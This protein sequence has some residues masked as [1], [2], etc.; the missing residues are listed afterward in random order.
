MKNYKTLEG[1]RTPHKGKHASPIKRIIYSLYR[2]FVDEVYIPKEV[3]VTVSG[4]PTVAKK[5]PGAVES[6]KIVKRRPNYHKYLKEYFIFNDFGNSI[7]SV[8]LGE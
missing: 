1:Y 2:R 4:Y 8:N 6:I 5:E 3:S 7:K